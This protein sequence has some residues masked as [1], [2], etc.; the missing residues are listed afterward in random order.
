MA[1][2]PIF[3]G[4]LERTGTSLLYALLASHPRIAMT[5]RTNWWTFFDG[6]F[7]DLAHDD[8]LDR[9]LASMMRYRRHRKLDPDF[10]RLRREFRASEPSYCRLFGLL[11]EHH[12][13]R[14]GKP[15]WGDKS[16]HTERYADRVFHCFPSARILHM[17]RDPRDRYAS[18]L[19]RWHGNRGGV[20]SAT[21][22]W[23]DSVKLGEHYEATYPDRFMI[24]RYEDLAGDPEGTL[25]TICPFVN[26]SFESEMLDMGGASDFRQAG[27]NSSF[28]TFARGQIS[29]ASIGRYTSVLR[30][31]QVAFMQSRAGDMMVRH[32][33]AA[34]PVRLAQRA[35]VRYWLV[36][37]PRSSATMLAWRAREAYYNKTGRNP[38]RHTLERPSA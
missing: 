35:L 14:L 4:G 37:R 21:A 32:G 18:S 22:A 26:E 34:P 28:G 16:L 10:G 27:G 36:E 19:K 6:R 8:N 38:S 3:I 7:G 9:C 12:A 20:G 33:Y 5:R 17:V 15:R 31:T 11:E 29:T 13:Q 1:P 23:I 25:R 30:A 2:G 24:V